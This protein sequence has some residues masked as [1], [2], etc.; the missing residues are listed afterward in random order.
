MPIRKLVED[1]VTEGAES[2]RDVLSVTTMTP[3]WVL[4]LPKV[5]EF[6]RAASERVAQVTEAF[7]DE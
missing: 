6:R 4:A 2:A 7:D 3:N 1:L 5:K